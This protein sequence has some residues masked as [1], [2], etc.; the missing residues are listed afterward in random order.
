M[1]NLLLT[2]AALACLCGFYGNTKADVVFG[3]DP[4]GEVSSYV[5]KFAQL[6]QSG[7]RVVVDGPC[8]SACTLML[9]QLPMNQVCATSRAV[10]GFHAAS[11]Y[12][13]A[14]N[15]LVPSKEGSALIMQLYAPHVRAWINANGGLKPKMIYARGYQL[16]VQACY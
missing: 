1:K 5:D 2:A 13:D 3:N 4:G 10:F 6:R 16:G 9:G 8:L 12:N 7:E 14:T 11:Y 15:S